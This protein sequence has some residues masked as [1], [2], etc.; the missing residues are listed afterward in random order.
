M[1][2]ALRKRLRYAQLQ[3]VPG[4]DP[5]DLREAG[6]AAAETARRT[7]RNARVQAALEQLIWQEAEDHGW[8]ASAWR[9]PAEDE[10]PDRLADAAEVEAYIL[11]LCHEL[12]LLPPT[13]GEASE[14]PGEAPARSRTTKSTTT[15]PRPWLPSQRSQACHTPLARLPVQVQTPREPPHP[16]LAG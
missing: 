12:E 13:D 8:T 5:R 7:A 1:R 2:R 4:H 16:P 9:T 14:D 11:R 3:H 6:A 15:G 10:A